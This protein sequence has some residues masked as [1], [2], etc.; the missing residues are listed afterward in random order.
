MFFKFIA[1]LS[2]KLCFCYNNFI[3]HF[4]YDG[5]NKGILKISQIS[6]Q[7]PNKE[8]DQA[9]IIPL[10]STKALINFDENLV[11][12]MERSESKKKTNFNPE[13][14]NNYEKQNND[15]VI[16]KYLIKN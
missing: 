8:R 9:Y 11:I 13:K 16:K 6:T 1:Q 12:I 15:E 7:N 5:L 14:D 3:H 4:T 2:H 10:Y